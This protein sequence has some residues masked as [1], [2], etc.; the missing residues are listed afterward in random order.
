MNSFVLFLRPIH[1]LATVLFI[2]IAASV[3][4]ATK[5]S[6]Y[7]VVDPVTDLFIN[8]DPT[9]KYHPTDFNNARMVCGYWIQTDPV[10]QLEVARGI[11]V[12]RNGIM[13]HLTGGGLEM[14]AKNFSPGSE[15]KCVS[16]S[17]ILEDGSVIV[18]SDGYED[19]GFPWGDYPDKI[20]RIASIQINPELAQNVDP[21][22]Q[23]IVYRGFKV[24]YQG[25]GPVDTYVY[26]EDVSRGGQ[27][28]GSV[29]NYGYFNSSGLHYKGATTWSAGQGAPDQSNYGPNLQVNFLMLDGTGYGMVDAYPAFFERPIGGGIETAWRIPEGYSIVEEEAAHGPYRVQQVYSGPTAVWTKG[30]LGEPSLIPDFSLRRGIEERLN[31]RT[32]VTF[33]GH[34]F[35]VSYN[36]FS[37]GDAIAYREDNA[38]YTVLGMRSSL[39]A[40]AG[41]ERRPQS[42]DQNENWKDKILA[43]NDH[44]DLLATLESGDDP[45]APDCFYVLRD[46]PNIGRVRNTTDPSEKAQEN[47]Y[48]NT[49]FVSF[50][51]TREIGKS[52]IAK[53]KI[54]LVAGGTSTPGEDFEEGASTTIEWAEGEV[55]NKSTYIHLLDDSEVEPD[56]TVKVLIE[57]EGAA[58]EGATEFFVTIV[59]ND[60]IPD[61]SESPVITSAMTVSAQVGEA[62]SYQIVATNNPTSYSISDSVGNTTLPNG[63]VGNSAT[64]QIT[65]TPEAEGS[66]SI[67]IEASNGFGSDGKY[68]LVN[69]SAAPTPPKLTQTIDF[70]APGNMTYNPGSTFRLGASAS[71]DL[72]VNYTSSNTNVISISGNTATMRGVGSVI[73]TARQPGNTR[74]LAAASVARSITV[75]KAAQTINFPNP[76][77]QT[78]EPNGKFNLRAS[79]SSGLA[80]EYTSSNTKVISI[81][82]N[83]ATI[84][85]AG[86]AVITARQSG[87]TNF[88]PAP[89]RLRTVEVAKGEQLIQFSTKSIR[90][91][92]AGR[93][94]PLIARNSSNLDV[95][96]L[97]SNPKVISINGTTAT[98]RGKGRVRITAKQQGNKNWNPSEVQ[99]SV[100]VK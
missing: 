14:P 77:E 58:F 92:E 100:M 83:I 93:Q 39:L 50:N 98:I 95:I 73:I 81:S 96:F 42:T 5:P 26:L 60:T 2:A 70:P 62:F 34:L 97:S 71:S 11:F 35:G 88:N 48:G 25:F 74:Y 52:G 36:N 23:V 6:N 3:S 89:T 87:N 99:R 16:M 78:Y 54:S 49:G 59:S 57:V 37:Y 65:G 66:Y 68:L 1:T 75:G 86:S 9:I 82:G 8:E 55:G 21:V 41:D 22:I 20:S 46:H 53:A 18:G 61:T 13:K 56:E 67:W 15:R 94:F 63:F 51:F 24:E 84:R 79:A 72:A 43:M 4:A 64:G 38:T 40:L 47:Y 76:P 12:W 31:R 90:Y 45:N 91:V 10:S 19:A 29:Y 44:L 7:L 27:I 69:V 80:V 32:N 17:D 85:G 28:L 33:D 30:F